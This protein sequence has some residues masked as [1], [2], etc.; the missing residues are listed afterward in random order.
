[1]TPVLEQ[2]G[3]DQHAEQAEHDR[4][5]RLNEFDAWFDE[6][7]FAFVGEL[8]DVKCSANSERNGEEQGHTCD[9]E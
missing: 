2:A 9:Q 7:G 1:M 5:D 6:R 3:K 8:V 4:G